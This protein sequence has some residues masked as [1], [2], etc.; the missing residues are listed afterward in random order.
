MSYD[1]LPNMEMNNR[2]TELIQNTNAWKFI[3]RRNLHDTE[4]SDIASRI[5]PIYD[6]IHVRYNN[7][8]GNMFAM[9]VGGRV[10]ADTMMTK[11]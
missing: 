1:I 10:S 6:S 8:E 11:F 4:Q 5:V 3:H 7:V 2:I 9:P